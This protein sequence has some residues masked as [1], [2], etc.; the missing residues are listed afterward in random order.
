MSDFQINH[1]DIL[2]IERDARELRARVLADGL[3]ALGAWLRSRFGL[4]AQGRTA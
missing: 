3:R 2:R 4:A 1:A